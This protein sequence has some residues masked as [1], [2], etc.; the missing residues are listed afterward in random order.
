MYIY[1]I[2]FAIFYNAIVWQ[3]WLS[4]IIFNINLFIVKTE[5]F[6][7]DDDNQW[8]IIIKNNK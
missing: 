1:L 3:G 6:N 4:N 5:I 8:M 7:G 2:N